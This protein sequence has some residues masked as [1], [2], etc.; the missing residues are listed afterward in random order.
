MF[1]LYNDHKC[2]V[3]YY[4]IQFNMHTPLYLKTNSMFVP[5]NAIKNYNKFVLYQ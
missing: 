4:S 3:K 2:Y 1:I 5:F